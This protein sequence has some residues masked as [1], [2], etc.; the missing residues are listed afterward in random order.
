MET[1]NEEL[2]RYCHENE[3]TPL[4]Q[5]PVSE[6]R[7]VSDWLMERGWVKSTP[8]DAP[9]PNDKKASLQ[10]EVVGEEASE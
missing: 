10:G 8:L 9:Q 1:I 4:R 3:N 6:F 2:F 5:I 7:K